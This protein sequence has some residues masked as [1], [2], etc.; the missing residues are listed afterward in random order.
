MADDVRLLGT[1]R[2]GLPSRDNDGNQNA[3]RTSQYGELLSLPTGKGLLALADEGSYFLAVNGTPGTGLA[4]HAAPTDITIDTKPFVLIRNA[5]TVAEGVRL[6]LDYI[7]LQVTAAGTGGT[8]EQWCL[9]IDNILRY[10]SGGSALV[11]V[12]PNMQSTAASKATC[13][14]GA[15]TAAAASSAQRLLGSGTV[16]T[17]IPVAADTYMF[18]F[19]AAMKDVGAAAV[20]GTTPTMHKIPCP[21]VVLGPGE[22]LLLHLARASQSAAASYELTAAWFEK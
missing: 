3:V 16:R 6:Y 14:A 18:D 1:A 21:P 20:N 2:R 9:K 13:H 12:C 7:R 8:I 4:G 15:V 5:A 19:G 22:S 17:A 10:A 11:P